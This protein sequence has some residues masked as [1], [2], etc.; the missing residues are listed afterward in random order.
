M[1]T[2]KYTVQGII[3]Y[4]KY[5]NEGL[6]QKY[7]TQTILYS[8]FRGDTADKNGLKKISSKKKPAENTSVV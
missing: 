3:Y 4:N 7:K 2:M 5:I 8:T 1:I 6:Q